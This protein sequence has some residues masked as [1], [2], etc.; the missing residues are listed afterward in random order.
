MP[1]VSAKAEIATVPSFV[2]LK[3][4]SPWGLCVCMQL[5]LL[6]VYSCE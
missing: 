3:V 2:L 1:E 6:A 4:C 5:C